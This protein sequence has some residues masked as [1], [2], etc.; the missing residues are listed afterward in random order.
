VRA[1]REV[2]GR[3]PGN[4]FWGA[5]YE[6]VIIVGRLVRKAWIRYRWEDRHWRIAEQECS[7]TGLSRRRGLSGLEPEYRHLEKPLTPIRKLLNMRALR[8]RGRTTGG[9]HRA[10]RF[11][12][13]PHTVWG[14][15]RSCCLAWDR[16]DNV[17]IDDRRQARLL[18]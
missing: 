17:H 9:G 6:V 13:E 15:E 11:E 12:V 16:G 18:G 8:S 1:A 4:K 14:P 3:S 10:A 5:F 7:E 2:Q